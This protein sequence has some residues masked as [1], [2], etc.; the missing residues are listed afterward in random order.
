[1][2]EYE[3][4]SAPSP[5][6]CDSQ[7]ISLSHLFAERD[8]GLTFERAK[9][10]SKQHGGGEI[11]PEATIRDLYEYRWL[12]DG[13][14]YGYFLWSCKAKS[15]NLTVLPLSEVAEDLQACQKK[16]N[17]PCGRAIRNRIVGL[18]SSSRPTKP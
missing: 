13:A 11:L 8:R 15:L 5:K 10:I 6:L 18:E 12:A 1:M 9:A 7:A 16:G 17:D 2:T 3:F 4:D 14:H